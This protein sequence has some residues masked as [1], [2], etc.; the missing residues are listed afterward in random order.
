[1][2]IFEQILKARGLDN[3]AAKLFFEPDYETRHDPFLLPD[4]GAAV[5]RLVE[6]RLGTRVWIRSAAARHPQPPVRGCGSCLHTRLGASA[7]R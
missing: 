3:E 6:A 2:T 5:S 7:R 1:M 4:M